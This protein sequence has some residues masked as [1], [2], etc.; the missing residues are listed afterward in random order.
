MLSFAGR[1]QNLLYTGFRIAGAG[2]FPGRE[3]GFR[4]CASLYNI[5]RIY[6]VEN[7]G[8]FPDFIDRRS[9]FYKTLIL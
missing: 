9:F 3:M 6:L 4:R 5:G 8:R 2:F 1:G 7:R